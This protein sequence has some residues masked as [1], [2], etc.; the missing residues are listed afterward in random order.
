MLDFS[1]CSCS[2]LNLI[3]YTLVRRSRQHA[4]TN[5]SGEKRHHDVKSGERK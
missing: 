4:V 2:E 3:L 5:A 1:E